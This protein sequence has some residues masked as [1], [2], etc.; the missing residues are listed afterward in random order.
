MRKPILIGLIVLLTFLTLSAEDIEIKQSGYASLNWLDDN[1]L[2]FS[3]W[4]SN[5]IYLTDIEKGGYRTIDVKYARGRYVNQ[6][7]DRNS[8]LYKKLI[9]RPQYF[10]QQPVI[11]DIRTGKITT[12]YE[13]SPRVGPPSISRNG[14][15][16]FSKGD[17]IIVLDN[18]KP[19]TTIDINCYSNLIAIS[20]NGSI[21]LYNDN[22]DQVIMLNID[23]QVTGKIT[24]GTNSYFKPRWSSDG[25]KILLQA[26]GEG[27]YI[28]EL[29]T[30]KLR[31]V[32]EG[33]N[34][35]LV[36]NA[37]IVFTKTRTWNY[38][39]I[40]SELYFYE[41][42]TGEE[43]PLTN[44]PDF[45]EGEAAISPDLTKIAFID[46]KE[47]AIWVGDLE[48]EGGVPA[49]TRTRECLSSRAFEPVE[50][51]GLLSTAPMV[52]VSAPYIHQRW[53]TPDWFNGSWSCG[54][55][56]CM[57]AVQKYDKLPAHPITCSSP[58]EHTSDNGWY[59]PNEY[60][61]NGYT[62][63]ILGLAPGDTWV[64][65]AH[66]FICRELGAAYWDYMVAFMNQ[67]TLTSSYAG[68]DWS[69]LCS[70]VD[71]GYPMVSS[72]T[73][74]GYGHIQFFKGYLANHTI[75][76]ND[77]YG[78]ANTSPWGQYNGE[79]VYYDWPGY[80][81]GHVELAVN[82]LFYAQGTGG[83]DP[84][85]ADTIVDDLSDGFAKSGP[86]EYWHEWTGGYES[87]IWWTYSTD[88]SEDT[89]SAT[90]TPNLPRAGYWEVHA[91]IPGNYATTNAR[92]QVHHNAGV[93][94]SVVNQSIYSNE[95]VSLGTY[96][97]NKEDGGYVY[98]GDGAD[99][100]GHWLGVDA[101]WWSWR[102]QG[103][104]TLVD[105]LTTGFQYYGFMEYWWDWAGGWDHHIFYTYSTSASWDTNYAT[106]TPNLPCEGHYE[107]YVFIPSNNAVANSPYHIFSLDG[108]NV[109]WVN[110]S[111]YSSAW[112]SLGTYPFSTSGGYIRLGDGAG[113]S[114]SKMGFDAAKWSYRY[115]LSVEDRQQTIDNF[116]I[117]CYPNPFNG[118][119]TIKIALT[120]AF[121]ETPVQ[122]EI[123]DINGRV[124]FYD[125]Q[126]CLSIQEKG[127]R[128]DPVSP[129]RQM[130]W[131]PNP[132]I[133]SGI[134]FIIATSG[135]RSLSKRIIYLK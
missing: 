67:H 6:P 134:Y 95:W 44:I 47:G 83:D 55:T 74:L 30:S 26:A 98:L 112:V 35:E 69:T 25:S 66:G 24:D 77:P 40:S 118:A 39:I 91:Y 8:L 90:W 18:E 72:A 92:Y 14:R 28:Y 7:D 32:A 34:P 27:I 33:R 93:T 57:M 107:V 9:K 114:G 63:D 16:A 70:E 76:A 59:I 100:G 41:F 17:S 111:S 79:T 4:N 102:P 116:S 109:V 135:E 82:Q 94:A 132:S 117:S 71:A 65:G 50:P 52:M 88:A 108:E 22:N 75:I 128:N 43:Y 127:S 3:A 99:E 38:A 130:T 84:T 126:G 21:I 113:T 87:H 23:T 64:P 19:L 42:E 60:S 10:L 133:P 85:E 54:P 125:R 49:I 119:I 123:Y 81:N 104:D 78:D 1:T 101:T 131:T 61:Y 110:Q 62:Y 5:G 97:F 120:G 48:W 36:A 37:G 86:T 121:R 45:H 80:D 58:Y 31:R 2:V 96:I 56:S 68:T 12:L 106:W 124:V 11:Y 122:L 13:P 105:D 15:I 89:N 129:V 115:G 29:S 46:L 51:P 103:C 53:D 73:T 20:P